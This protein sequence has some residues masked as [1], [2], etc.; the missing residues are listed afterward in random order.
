MRIVK[1]ALGAEIEIKDGMFFVTATD[2]SLS[3]WGRAKGKTSKVVIV[4]GSAGDARIVRDGILRQPASDN[5]I[6]V[7]ITPECPH[8]PASRCVTTYHSFD[9][10]PLYTGVA[11]DIHSTNQ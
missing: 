3:G 2:K 9:E 4:C 11:R 1:T 7:R 10:V 6:Y 8:Y 5:L